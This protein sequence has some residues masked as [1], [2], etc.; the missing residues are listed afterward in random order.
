MKVPNYKGKFVL[1]EEG[2]LAT[3]RLDVDGESKVK[4]VKPSFLN[5]CK[6][7]TPVPVVAVIPSEAMRI[8]PHILNRNLFVNVTVRF[9]KSQ[10]IGSCKQSL[11]TGSLSVC[12]F[13]IVMDNV[14]KSTMRVVGVRGQ[15]DIRETDGML[16][17]QRK[18]P[19]ADSIIH[20]FGDVFRD[21]NIK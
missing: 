8:S 17:Q 4:L 5:R 19:V 21:T 3:T 20:D 13:G 6:K 15:R 2:E 1:D 18:D 11:Q 12:L 14:A 10:N 9:L 16:R 7:T